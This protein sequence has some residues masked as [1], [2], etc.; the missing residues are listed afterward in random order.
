MILGELKRVLKQVGVELFR[1]RPYDS[2]T[3]QLSGSVI[4]LM[5]IESTLYICND[6]QICLVVALVKQGT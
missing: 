6:T 2:Q 4:R 3:L 5:D 1:H